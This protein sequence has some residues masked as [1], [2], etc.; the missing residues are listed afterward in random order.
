MNTSSQS[1]HYRLV[2]TK[3][4][5]ASC[6]KKIEQALQRVP[7]V[8]AVHV[9]F[10][11]RTASVT[12]AQAISSE[13]LI[14]ALKEAGYE[15]QWV[16]DVAEEESIKTTAEETYYHQLLYKTL[17]AFCIGLPIF[18][19]AM[20]NTLPSLFTPLGYKLN[21]LL[22][23][24]SLSVLI[25]SGGHFFVGAWNGIKNHSANMDTLIALGT[26]VA[27]LY[28]I[29]VL[30]FSNI[31]PVMAQHVYFEAATAI[32]ALVNLGALLEMRARRHTSDAI[33]RLMTLQPKTARVVRHQNEMDIPIEA[34]QTG[35]LIRVRPGEQ[36]PVDGLLTEGSSTIDEAMLTGEPLPKEKHIGDKVVAGTL[37]KTGS[38][39]FKATHVGKD[40]V[41]AQIIQTVQQ[42][43]SSKPALARLADQVSA[44]FVP[45]VMIIA[46]FTALIWFNTPMEDKLGYMLVTAMSVLVIAC[47]CALGLAVPISV[48]IGVGKGAEYGILIRQAEALQQAGALTTIILDKT[49]TIT[50]GQPQVVGV[51]PVPGWSEQQLLAYAANLEVGSEHPLAEAI[52]NSA[53]AQNITPSVV[54]HFQA[55]EGC[56][57][58]GIVNDEQL[59]LGNRKLMQQQNIMITSLIAEADKFAALGQT[60]IYIAV[61]QQAIGFITIADPLKP[62]SKKAIQH[63]QQMGLK[64]VMITGDHVATAKAI[65]AQVGINDILAEVLPQDKANQIKLLQQKGEKVGMVGDGI[66]DA[67]AL[68]QAE[69]GFAIGTGTDV[70]IESAGITLMRGSLLSVV[71]AIKLSKA[72]TRNM[73]ENLLGAFIYNILGIPIAAGI[74]F[75]FFG[76]LMN[77]MLAGLAM[78]LSSVTVV[79][80]ANRLRFLKFSDHT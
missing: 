32:I 43:Q 20:S 38:F 45:L 80:N 7:D 69:V 70:A 30:L 64:V 75:P 27:W 39:V 46:I 44:I 34:V 9:N 40:T 48:M 59:W 25:Y 36:I 41:L 26:G 29:L 33:K 2:I 67:P 58:S 3:I 53:K 13:R 28:S 74:L 55:I 50:Q 73:K 66:N 22:A 49:G 77:P 23:A 24:L 37:N 16:K 18:V 51:Y 19:L 42:A 68:A 54:S 17:F 12:A 14:Q 71:D 76:L 35:D 6:V 52:L 31:V 15:A 65:A 11:E 8:E 63:L 5:C 60:P 79:S 4:N 56:G 62:D 47:P 21:W 61:N 57:V 78:A 72:T 1:F 10:A